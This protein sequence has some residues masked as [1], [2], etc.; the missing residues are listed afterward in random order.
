[1]EPAPVR[2]LIHA[3]VAT[4]APFP[5]TLGDAVSPMV[6]CDDP[7][8]SG[9]PPPRYQYKTKMRRIRCLLDPARTEIGGLTRMPICALLLRCCARACVRVTE[10][11]MTTLRV[12]P[13]CPTPRALDT[14]PGLKGKKQGVISLAPRVP[15]SSLD[16]GELEID[17]TD[18][19]K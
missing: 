11:H 16:E 1:M 14:S 15:W 19:T 6:S 4:A 18:R 2:R 3:C 17:R 9:C 13:V 5:C 7:L 10:I 8:F 12:N